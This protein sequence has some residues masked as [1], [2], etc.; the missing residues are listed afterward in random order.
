MYLDISDLTSKLAKLS[1]L[2]AHSNS[3]LCCI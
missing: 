1:H 2:H 3:L